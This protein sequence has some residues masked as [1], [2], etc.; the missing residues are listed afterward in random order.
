MPPVTRNVVDATAL[1]VIAD[2][3]R[4]QNSK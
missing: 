2:W 1:E 4:A 3:I